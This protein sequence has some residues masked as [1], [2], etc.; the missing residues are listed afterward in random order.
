MKHAYR[1]QKWT[2][3]LLLLFLVTTTHRLM[4]AVHLGD[5]IVFH[6]MCDASAGVSLNEDLFVSAD[7]ES[8]ALRIYSRAK[9][10]MPVA[11]VPLDRFL[12]TDRKNPEGDIEAAA[13]VGDTIYWISSHGRNRKG[14]ARQSRDRFFATKISEKNGQ[15]SVE[16]EG[17]P[18]QL[19]LRD[20]VSAPQLKQF[21]LADAS[22]RAPK[23]FGALNIEGL[24]AG[25]NGSLLIG[26]RNPV[27]HGKALIVPLLNPAEVVSGR[28]RARLGD[29]ILVDLEGSG[30]RDMIFAHDTFYIIGGSP[31]TGGHS[32]L[33]QW[34]G[35]GPSPEDL[36]VFHPHGGNPEA[37]LTMPGHKHEL[38][39]LT[40][41]G[42]RV[43]KTGVECKELPLE[44]RSFRGFAVKLKH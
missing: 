18:Y 10:G 14:H 20:L 17:R 3:I 27:P 22:V 7:D 19:L 25:P 16:P 35:K 26:F 11:Q 37:L 40:D 30:I 4:G 33:F 23:D 39:M 15:P 36:G 44:K 32:K 42:T 34:D 43:A 31:G 29:P 24:A 13:Q 9:G 2:A 28:A 8:N 21:G 6:G 41:E 38:W 12:Q 1:A 5:P